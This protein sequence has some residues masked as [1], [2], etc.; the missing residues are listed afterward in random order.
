MPLKTNLFPSSFLALSHVFLTI[1]TPVCSIH[2]LC[3]PGI[4]NKHR[5]GFLFCCVSI[6][7]NSPN[8]LVLPKHCTANNFPLCIAEQNTT[9]N[10]QLLLE[11]HYLLLTNSF[12]CAFPLYSR[13][14]CYTKCTLVTR[15]SQF[16]THY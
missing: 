14:K 10:V 15:K 1:V 6:L 7:L 8:N 9:Q 16:A 13:A 5:S 3:I 12:Q 4:Q 2:F 11:N